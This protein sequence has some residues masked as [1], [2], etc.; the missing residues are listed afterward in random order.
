MKKLRSIIF[1]GCLLLVTSLLIAQGSSEG[2]KS[3]AKTGVTLEITSRWSEE[4][5]SSI[6][7]RNHLNA[8]NDADNGVT[9]VQ[10]HINDEM[11][12]Y[13]KLRT[14][15]ATGEFPNIFFDYGGSRTIDYVRSNIL[16]DLKP[17]LDADPEWRDGFLSLF[18]KWEYEEYPG[19]WGVPGEFYAV[20]I[21]YNKDIFAEVGIEIPT[22]IDEFETACDALLAAGYI[23]LALG[24]RDIWRAGHFSNNIVL[25]T[26]GAQA[27]TDLATRKLKYDSP[28]MLAVYARIQDYNNRGYFGPNPVNMDHNMEKTAFHT[29]KSAMH[30]DG[31]WYIGEGSTSQISDIIGVFPFPTINPAHKNSWQGGAAAGFSVVDKGNKAENDAAVELIKTFTNGEYMKELQKVN[32]GGV[33]AVKFTPDESVIDDL[34]RDYMAMIEDAKEF[35]DDIQTYDSLPSLLETVRLALQGLFVGK[36][37]AQCGAEIVNE[38]AVNR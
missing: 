34:T 30:M 37:P 7:F 15:F 16:L 22:T 21:F 24:E 18:D 13:D 17:Y 27:V 36:T 20:G 23:P 2:K 32:K 26:Y 6:Y 31:S 19:V 3:S 28:E 33:Y 11:S 5:P 8:Y 1:I 14:K 10:D 9:L 4:T 25:K 38:I 29:G 35:R 12:Y